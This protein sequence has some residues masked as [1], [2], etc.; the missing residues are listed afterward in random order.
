[1][2]KKQCI[3]FIGPPG[4][5]KDTQSELLA[6]DYGF[7]HFRTS[8]IVEEKI[9]NADPNDPVLAQ[10]KVDYDSG[11]LVNF[12]LV[13]S[14][15]VDKIRALGETSQ[16]VAFSGSF[17]TVVEAEIEIPVCEESYGKENIHFVYIP[18][19]EETSVKRNSSRRICQANQHPFPNFPEY[20]D[21]KEC[22]KDKS[23][24]IT[25][26]IDDPKII[27]VRYQTYL[28]DTKPVLEYVESLKFSVIKVD[29]EQSIRDVHEEVLRRIDESFHESEAGMV[30]R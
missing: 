30:F 5:G 29:G 26:S 11:K 4:A 28:H 14:W 23:A 22:P 10:A 24:I 17:R 12:K 16:S 27:T 15:V 3:I 6:D 7:N 9:R 2:R 19:S 8:R 13:A 25:R 1:M 20:R 18:I 21:L